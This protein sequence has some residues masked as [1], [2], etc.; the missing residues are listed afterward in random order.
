MATRFDGDPLPSTL[1]PTSA[2]I[3]VRET[4]I[5]SGPVK[6]YYQYLVMCII[7]IIIM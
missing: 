2:W 6:Y 1:V 4:I 5:T 7:A 3:G